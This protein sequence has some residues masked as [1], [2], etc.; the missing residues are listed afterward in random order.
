MPH[1]MRHVRLYSLTKLVT[2]RMFF[3]KKVTG[4]FWPKMPFERS[5]DWD[6]ALTTEV[7]RRSWKSFTTGA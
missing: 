5:H 3:G 2:I 6:V 7:P 4:K 1:C